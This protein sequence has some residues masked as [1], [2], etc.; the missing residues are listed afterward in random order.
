M[1]KRTC[2]CDDIYNFIETTIEKC[3]NI[4]N[5]GHRRSRVNTS[6]KNIFTLDGGLKVDYII[7][8]GQKQ[9]RVDSVDIKGMLAMLFKS[10]VS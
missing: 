9:F 6:G 5:D 2:E 10:L 4:H 8:K 1:D 7:L 3:F